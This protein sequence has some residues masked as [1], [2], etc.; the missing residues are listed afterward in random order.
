MIKYEKSRKKTE[1]R[2]RQSNEY[3]ETLKEYTGLISISWIFSNNFFQ[4]RLKS[5]WNEKFNWS[6]TL[7]D[8][9]EPKLWKNWL[10]FEKT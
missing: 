5:T 3:T 6:L 9:T 4:N 7:N 10:I 1:R 8:E 2:L